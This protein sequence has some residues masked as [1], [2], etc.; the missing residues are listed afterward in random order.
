MQNLWRQLKRR[1]RIR[2]RWLS[3]GTVVLVSGLSALAFHQVDGPPT[4]NW[5]ELPTFATAGV[6]ESGDLPA[7][8]SAQDTLLE[9]VI[10]GTT[11]DVYK[12][13]K[14]VCG[15][16]TAKLGRMSPKAI[17]EYASEHPD[18]L[19]ELGEDG[20]VTFTETVDDLSPR[21]KETG[22]F[23][24]DKNDNLSLFDGLPAE[25]RVIRTFFQLDV[26]SLKSSLPVELVEQLYTGIRIKDVEQYRSVLAT[27]SRFASHEAKPVTEAEPI[28]DVNSSA[29]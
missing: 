23:G 25:D 28:T 19:L 6:M 7:D 10:S 27:F 22:R 3:L 20:S 29:E 13:T 24:I 14:Y 4:G 8:G 11:R 12:E 26:Q 21:C 1:L 5:L 9:I 17:V 16:E 18:Y 2:K 15:E